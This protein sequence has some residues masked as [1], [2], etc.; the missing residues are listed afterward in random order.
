MKKNFLKKGK[1]N[2]DY[3]EKAFKQ[4][5]I[6]IYMRLLFFR[7]FSVCVPSLL[8]IFFRWFFHLFFRVFFFR[9]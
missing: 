8:R 9:R 1:K 2:K 3:F 7:F 5:R 6:Y 4:K